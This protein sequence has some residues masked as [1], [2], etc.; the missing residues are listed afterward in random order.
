MIAVLV[1]SLLMTAPVTDTAQT[2]KISHYAP[3][4]MEQVIYNRQHGCC[5]RYSLPLNLP[6]V[7]GYAALA[8]REMIGE[9]VRLCPLDRPCEMFLVTDCAGYADGGYEW[10]MRY[11]VIAEVDYATALRWGTPGRVVSGAL[12]TEPPWVG[13][14]GAAN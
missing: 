9:V 4:V 3:G 2:G 8:D 7:D 11:N 13:E 10:M 14:V 12:R 5:G 6:D 1:L